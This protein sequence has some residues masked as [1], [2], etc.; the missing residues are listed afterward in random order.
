MKFSESGPCAKRSRSKATPIGLMLLGLLVALTLTSSAGALTRANSASSATTPTVPLGAAGSFAVLA[1]TVPY[2]T[3][4]PTSAI[5][6]NV[7]LDPGPGSGIAGLTCSEVSGA[8]YAVDATGLPC[9]SINKPLLDTAKNDLTTAYLDAQG[10]IPATSLGTGD[11]ALG[12]TLAP[13]IY[14]FGHA[15]TDNLIGNLTLSGDQNAVWVFQ[16]SSDLR[17]AVGSTMTLTGGAQSCNVFWQVTST[18]VLGG[19]STF[20]GTILALTS[21]TVGNGAAIDGRLLAQTNEVTLIADTIRTPGCVGGLQAPSREIYCDPSGKAYDLVIGQNLLPP[22]NTLGLVDAYVD[23]VTGAKS[24]NF[25]AVVPT[26]TATTPTAPTPTPTP[27][28]KPRPVP[29]KPTPVPPA[30]TPAKSTAGNAVPT[31]SPARHPFGLTG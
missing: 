17:T 15:T 14:S 19:S 26:P 27:T 10:R 8:I 28:P 16:A 29:R 11:N 12:R 18:A 25:P 9:F 20:V 2:I 4:V 23:P 22:Y 1:G 21:I 5:I 6:G 24:C 31:P 7:G 30:K 13:G 3:N